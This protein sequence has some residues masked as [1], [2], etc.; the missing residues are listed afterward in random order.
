MLLV[1]REGG[2]SGN[3]TW[4][5]LELR[6]E[7]PSLYYT[8]HLQKKKIEKAIYYSNDKVGPSLPNCSVRPAGSFSQSRRACCVLSMPGVLVM[9]YLNIRITMS[10]FS[11]ALPIIRIQ[12]VCRN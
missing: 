12:P 10:A 8:S 3:E 7:M 4:S 6:L 5:I 9:G 1:S 11:L 2:N